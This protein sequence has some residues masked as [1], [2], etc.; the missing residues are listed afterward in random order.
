MI[1]TPEGYFQEF[2]LLYEAQSYLND[3][4]SQIKRDTPAMAGLLHELG[5]LGEGLDRIEEK[6]RA[7][8]AENPRKEPESEPIPG[9]PAIGMGYVLGGLPKPAPES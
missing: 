3:L 2:V 5:E 8:A 6:M 7:V 4:I 1:E 9:Y